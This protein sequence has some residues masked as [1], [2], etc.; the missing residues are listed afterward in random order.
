MELP[1]KRIFMNAFFKSQFNYCPTI[2][3]FHNRPLNNKINRLHERC[4]RIIYN[5]KHPNFEELLNK[6]NSVS[7]HHNNVHALAIEMYK[8]TNTMS[9]EIMNERFK[10]KGNPHYN[11]RDTSQFS[12]DPIYS[13]SL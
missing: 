11:L 5:N 1:K 9:P 2:W 6:D 10:L 8:V 4:L 13:V 3:M 12:V 7:V